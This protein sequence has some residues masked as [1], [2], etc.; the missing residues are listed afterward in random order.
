MKCSR[1]P[2]IQCDNSLLIDSDLN[3]LL[4]AYNESIQ[5]LLYES[6]EGNLHLALC[7]R[8]IYVKMKSKNPNVLYLS[9]AI[10]HSLSLLCPTLYCNYE[11][12]G[13]PAWL[14]P[15]E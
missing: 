12:T 14:W 13:G 1:D 8:L 3:G 15:E 11:R 10:D 9:N 2:T 7:P 6:V 5:C 4:N